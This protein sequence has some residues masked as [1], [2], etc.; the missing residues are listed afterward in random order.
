[1]YE[2]IVNS[3]CIKN[4]RNYE[5][6]SVKLDEKLNIFIGDNGQGKTNFIE[7]IYICAFGKSFRTNKERDL[8]KIGEDMTFIALK[9]FKNSR[10]M[11]LDFKIR[12]DNKKDIKI[13]GVHISKISEL[14]GNLNIIIFSPEDLKLVKNGPAERRKFLD[15][16]IAHINNKYCTNII[17]YQKI[18]DHKNKLLKEIKRNKNLEIYNDMLDVWDEQLADKGSQIIVKRSEFTTKLNEYSSKIHYNITNGLEK[19]KIE[20]SSNMK[21]DI[22]NY[23]KIYMEMLK[24]NK[25]SRRKDIEKGYTSFGPHRDDL[26]LYINDIDIRSYGSQGQQRTAALALKLSEIDIVFEETDEYPVLLLDD[27]MSELD[28]GRQNFLLNSLNNVQTIITTTDIANIDNEN[29][30]KSKVFQI[31][32]GKLI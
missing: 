21:N 11:N 10:E 26:A 12:K 17:E 6:L 24:N 30:S 5:N 28:K 20:Y 4:Y 13:N 32:K 29:I 19:L 7:S 22:N 16:E 31:K 18:L 27:V 3:V 14:I 8:I 1:V 9:Y 15:K 23:D 25:D 2:L